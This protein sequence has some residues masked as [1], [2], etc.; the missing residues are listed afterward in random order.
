MLLNFVG[1]HF[2]CLLALEIK[3][4]IRGPECNC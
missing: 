1:V 4:G 2:F 3:T